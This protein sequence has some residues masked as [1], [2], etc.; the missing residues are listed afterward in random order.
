MRTGQTFVEVRYTCDG[1]GVFSEI[2]KNCVLPD[3]YECPHGMT[4]ATEQ[5]SPKI[6]QT[7][8]TEISEQPTTDRPL[9]TSTSTEPAASVPRDHTSEL[10]ESETTDVPTS[11]TE[12]S[13]GTTDSEP[14][15]DNLTTATPTVLT[16]APS[17]QSSVPNKTSAYTE[18]QTTEVLTFETKTTVVEPATEVI[19]ETTT[20]ETD[21]KYEN[22]SDNQTTTDSPTIVTEIAEV[23]TTSDAP[24]ERTITPT[25]ESTTVTWPAIHPATSEFNT[26]T[27]SHYLVNNHNPFSFRFL[28]NEQRYNSR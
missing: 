20:T 5:P 3:E 9:T 6:E 22:P 17:D 7:I 15:M 4:P 24:E 18:T 11:V 2:E 25:T 8:A 27:E 13:D 23:T 21:R 19:D 26:E 28:R 16:T 12:N 14:K 1:D 10:T